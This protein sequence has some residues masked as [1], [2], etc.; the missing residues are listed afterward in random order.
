M[1]LFPFSRRRRQP[2]ATG[3]GVGCGGLAKGGDVGPSWSTCP[4]AVIGRG[5]SQFPPRDRMYLEEE[6]GCKAATANHRNLA[7]SRKEKGEVISLLGLPSLNQTE[8]VEFALLCKRLGFF[9]SSIR[10]R[11]KLAMAREG[12]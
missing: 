8:E 12:Q 7:V 1:D 9:S 5:S 3:D 4:R 11:F 2:P 6:V 10:G